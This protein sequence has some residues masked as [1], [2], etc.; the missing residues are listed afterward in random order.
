MGLFSWLKRKKPLPIE[1][2]KWN[3]MWELWV[4]EKTATPYTEL[5]TYQSEV[6]NGGHMQFFDNV[7]NTADLA[8]HIEALKTVL[9]GV[10]KENIAVGYDAYLEYESLGEPEDE[11]FEE[12][13]DR[14]DEVFYEYESEIEQI[15]KDYAATFE[16]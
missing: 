16:V 11:R 10:L 2:Q 9:C 7:S 12:I 15:L 8:Q 4:E 13:F 1:A 5:M 14:L 6:N 3:K